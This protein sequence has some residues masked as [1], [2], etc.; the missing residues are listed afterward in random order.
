ME[1]K[2]LRTAFLTAI[3]TILQ[4]YLNDSLKKEDNN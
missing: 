3:D 2:T 1:H 4:Q